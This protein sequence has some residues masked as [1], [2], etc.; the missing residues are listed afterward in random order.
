MGEANATIYGEMLAMDA[1][2]TVLLIDRLRC[3]GSLQAVGGTSYLSEILEK[4]PV[5]SHGIHYAK[6]VAECAR[7][8]RLILMCMKV[9]EALYSE[10]YPAELVRQKMVE[11]LTKL[12][13]RQE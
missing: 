12:T 2:D 6:I 10:R 3:K 8:R 11:S 1:V 7:K 5:A 9:M 13:P 4:V